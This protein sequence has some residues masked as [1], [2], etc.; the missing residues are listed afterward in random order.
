MKQ[1]LEMTAWRE[2]L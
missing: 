2:M 1:C